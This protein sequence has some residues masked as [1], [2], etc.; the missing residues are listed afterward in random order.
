MLT[1]NILRENIMKYARTGRCIEYS[2]GRCGPPPL[3]G[4]A[5]ARL[6]QTSRSLTFTCLLGHRFPGGIT[7]MTFYCH[8]DGSWDHSIPHCDG[9]YNAFERVEQN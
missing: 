1:F 5:M 8:A 4:N 9:Q 3:I 6:N 7:V 2:G